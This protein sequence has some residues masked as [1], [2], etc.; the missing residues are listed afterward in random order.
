M[1]K[2][3]EPVPRGFHTVTHVIVVDDG[4][5]ALEFYAKAL[6]AKERNRALGPGGKIWHAE[7]EVGDSVIM[8][9]D[10]FPDS[11]MKSPRSLRGTSA[12]AWLYVPD[13]DAAFKRAV[14]A[15]AKAVQ[16]P[17]TMFWGDRFGSFTDPFGHTWSLATHVEDVS[18][19]EREKRRLAAMKAM[20]GSST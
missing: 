9:S 1:P 10:E 5:R 16:E 18:P 8:L 14:S 17:Q 4:A 20:V 6:S 19:A 11:E 15:G 3:P 7:I 2:A 13:V 12:S